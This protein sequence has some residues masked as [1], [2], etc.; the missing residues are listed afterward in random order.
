M[1]LNLFTSWWVDPKYS[2]L[3]FAVAFS[4]LWLIGITAA[5]YMGRKSLIFFIGGNDERLSLAKFQVIIWTF[6]VISSYVAI[7]FI[8]VPRATDPAAPSVITEWVTIPAQILMLMGI[9]ISGTVLSSIISASNEEMRT[10]FVSEITYDPLNSQFRIKG[11]NFG[12][13]RGSVRIHLKTP[14]N[15]KWELSIKREDWKDSEITVQAEKK[16]SAVI[17]GLKAGAQKE[18]GK[19]NSI[20]AEISTATL[21]AD[22]MRKKADELEKEEAEVAKIFTNAVE[23]DVLIVDTKN[24]KAAY[25]LITE[26]EIKLGRSTIYYEFVDFFRDDLNPNVL[27]I[28]KYQLFGWTLVAV[29]LYIYKFL[30]LNAASHSLPNIDPTVVILTGASTAGYLAGKFK[31]SGS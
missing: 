29:V 28:L 14:T 21:T 23:R 22:E 30:Q 20:K 31:P 2:W 5:K 10:A 18:L 24:G 8:Y 6:V 3:L 4:A 19:L 27:S 12:I 13:D 9:S 16:V 26:P 17:N 7:M 1:K 25:F 15:T 11:G